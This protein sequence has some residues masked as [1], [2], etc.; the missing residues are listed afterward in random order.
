MRKNADPSDSAVQ[1]EIESV[2]LNR[3]GEQHPDWRNFSWEVVAVELGL[4]AVW[5]KAKP[6]AVWKTAGNE[7]VVAEC[8]SRVGE[9]TSGHKGKLARD[10]LKLLALRN[11][12]PKGKQIRCLLIMPKELAGR[13]DGDGWFPAALHLAAE[14]VPIPLSESELKKLHKATRLQS[15][16]Q[17]RTKRTEKDRGA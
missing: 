8:Y 6:D 4:P 13:L 12:L 1:Q 17:A 14:I 2:M 11:A 9:L 10:A 15:Q 5:Q 7:V 3:L 16:G